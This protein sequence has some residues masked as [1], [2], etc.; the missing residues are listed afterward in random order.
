MTCHTKHITNI[1]T[2]TRA[3]TKDTKTRTPCIL[4]EFHE[5]HIST[6]QMTVITFPPWFKRLGHNIKN[7]IQ[8]RPFWQGRSK[9]KSH[10]GWPPVSWTS[11]TRDARAAALQ[12][13]GRSVS[14]AFTVANTLCSLAPEN[15]LSWPKS[16]LQANG[17]AHPNPR[18][19]CR[20]NFFLF[21]F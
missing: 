15:R 16:K 5:T 1:S 20:P 12:S 4:Q 3:R 6:L 18:Q 19:N 11:Q 8:Q 13:T 10:P 9:N 14:L 21:F 7:V 17:S 2:I